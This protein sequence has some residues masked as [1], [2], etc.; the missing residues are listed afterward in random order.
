MTEKVTVRSLIREMQIEIRDTDDLLPDRAAEL[1]NRL[2][3]LLGNVLDEL[4]EADMEYRGVLLDA[5]RRH[6]K[7]NRARI[8]AESTG[9]YAR[10]REAQDTKKLTE[11]LIITLR[12]YGRS[13]QE[14]MRLSR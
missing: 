8:D 14:E 3:A 5:M 13:K 2:T 4:R 12:S 10:M 1:L 6:E 11:Q 9:A 7:A